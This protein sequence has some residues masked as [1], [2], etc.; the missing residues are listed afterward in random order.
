MRN[1]VVVLGSGRL[2]K[3]FVS[4]K[5]SWSWVSRK[6]EGINF[7]KTNWYWR[8]NDCSTV[9]NCIANTGTYDKERTD[10]WQTNYVG[11]MNL[12]DWCNSTNQKLVHIST[13]YIY[14]GSKENATEND[15]P[16]P[17]KTWYA[18][19][20]MLGDAYVQARCNNYLLI[21]TSFKERPWKFDNA[22]TT[23]VGNFDYIDVIVG[24][25]IRLIDN[26][27][28]GLFNVGHSEPWNLYEMA[29]QTKPEVRESFNVLNKLMPRNTTMSVKK[30]E[31][32]LNDC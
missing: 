30:M 21:R 9:V 15:I 7:N 11:V 27:A 32:F 6:F 23:Q 16:M 19:T 24:L 2:A 4:Q 26:K 17:N 31:D 22:I 29:I 25:I 3:E 12:V 20:K 8:I 5:P 18:H 13:D 10:H 28:E 1:R 14:A